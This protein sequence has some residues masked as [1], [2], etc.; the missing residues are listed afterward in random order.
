[1]LQSINFARRKILEIAE[2]EKDRGA[3]ELLFNVNGGVAGS[4]VDQVRV[5]KGSHQMAL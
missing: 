4:V 2:V 1:M 5:Q 3:L